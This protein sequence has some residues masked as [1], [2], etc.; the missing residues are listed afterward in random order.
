M[1]GALTSEEAAR[2]L[3]VKLPTIYA[4]VSRGIL[5]SHRSADGRRSL[6][7]VGEVEALARRSRTGQRTEGR[8]ATVATSVTEMRPRSVPG[9]GRRRRSVRSL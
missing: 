5:I 9:P 1:A 3:G 4:Y 2:R 7:D 6:F 8:L